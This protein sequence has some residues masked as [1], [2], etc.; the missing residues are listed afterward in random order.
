MGYE[1][2]Y[3]IT[4][5]L[6]FDEQTSLSTINADG[7]TTRLADQIEC[8]NWIVDTAKKKGCR[9][10][11]IIGDVFD[12]RVSIDISVLHM[13][14]RA[15]YRASMEFDRVHIVVGNHDSYLR[16]PKLHSLA[17]FNAV[18]GVN[19]SS[20]IV[21]HDQPV[22]THML[23]FVPWH[24]DEEAFRRAVNKTL[25]KPR[26]AEYLF[27]HVLLKDVYPSGGV[28]AKHLR[29]KEWKQ[30][31]LGD[32]H[33]PMQVNERI[34]YVGAPMQFNYGDADGTRGF[35]VLD[36]DK[37]TFEFVE[38]TVS[39]RF[40]VLEDATPRDIGPRDFVRIRAED[41]EVAEA[42]I[43]EA[44]KHA[45]WIENVTADVEEVLPR[46]DVHAKDT[47][48]EVLRRYAEHA[49]GMPEVDELVEIGLEILQ[50]AQG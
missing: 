49:T 45:T 44:K 6:Q 28:S 4:A 33:E 8:F 27:A 40:H 48:E 5:D 13:V 41:P 3:A 22:S 12:S 35:L 38:N 25:H 17:V 16:S 26:V 30:V 47:H 10:L 50:E 29:A 21:I 43:R 2:R 9:E 7:I 32:V 36:A 11:I 34:R 39:P 1:S 14:C 46:L 24:D 20:R 37:D 15:V 31:I 23:A 42:A 19:W 18:E